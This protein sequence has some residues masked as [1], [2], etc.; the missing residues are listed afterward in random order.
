MFAACL[1][2][3]VWLPAIH[4]DA[5]ASNEP[6]NYVC[7]SNMVL[8]ISKL[9]IHAVR[10]ICLI[11]D[12]AGDRTGPEHVQ[13]WQANK[14]WPRQTTAK[15]VT[16]QTDQSNN[17]HQRPTP[18]LDQPNSRRANDTNPTNID[19]QSNQVLKFEKER[20]L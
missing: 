3:C 1:L 16:S 19:T 15:Q 8:N 12:L 6:M 14:K 2:F 20:R 10:A 17:Q 9:L 13:V 7:L 4:L 18:K 11:A 5:T